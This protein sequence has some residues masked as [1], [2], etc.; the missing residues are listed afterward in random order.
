MCVTQGLGGRACVV[1]HTE[2][3]GQICGV[4]SVSTV[5]M[6]LG[7]SCRSQAHTSKNLH[8]LSQLPG[9]PSV[10]L[11]RGCHDGSPRHQCWNLSISNHTAG[12]WRS[13]WSPRP[14][15][16]EEKF[17]KA[18]IKWRSWRKEW[19]EVKARAPSSLFPLSLSLFGLCS[20]CSQEVAELRMS[21]PYIITCLWR[22]PVCTRL[23]LDY[24]LSLVTLP[25]GVGRRSVPSNIINLTMMLALHCLLFSW[26][27][28]TF[29]I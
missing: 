9:G 12:R 20:P 8:F 18:G 2:I 10:V 19:E 11:K 5:Y 4:S 6:A 16:D 24:F 29:H 1:T 3:R 14:G 21:S 7:I 28:T 13:A 17:Q 25:S 27:S 22:G 15:K 23:T 26:L